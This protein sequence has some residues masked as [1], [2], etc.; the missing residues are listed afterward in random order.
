MYTKS[1]QELKLED[2]TKTEPKSEREKSY[3]KARYRN[4]VHE[5]ILKFVVSEM[6]MRGVNN[7]LIAD[8]LGKDPG[9]ISKI[10]SKPSNLT[11]D[12]ICEIGMALDADAQPPVFLRH[13]E[14]PQS[15]FA[16][17]LIERALGTMPIPS[18]PVVDV[19]R[20]RDHKEPQTK[21]F[22][23]E[24]ATRSAGRSSEFQ[25]IEVSAS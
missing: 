9:Q 13:S 20:L 22:Q 4:R 15:Q 19:K 16:H 7:K 2:T 18:E 24:S 21:R 8:R 23:L 10:L 11:I 5:S 3:A 1:F 6:K 17:P 14:I 25:S 12:T